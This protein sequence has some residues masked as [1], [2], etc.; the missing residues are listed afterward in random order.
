MKI[1]AITGN[2]SDYDLM[3]P[4][5]RY[6]HA[7]PD[8]N[9]QLLVSGA[10]L[11]SL[12]GYT[13]DAIR[14]DGFSILCQIETI[15]TA[16]DKKSRLN[17]AS[18]L[19]QHSIDP[20][21]QFNPDLILYV[22]DREEVIV[23]SLLSCYLEIPSMHF[24]S[25]DHASDGNTDN[26]IRHAAAKL[27]SLHMVSLPQHKDRLIAMGESADRIHYVGSMALDNFV[28]HQAHSKPDL[29]KMLSTEFDDFALV[30]YHPLPAER[31]TYF[32]SYANLLDALIE[33]NIYAFINAPN[34]DPGNHAGLKIIDHYKQYKNFVYTKNLPR[35]LFLSI[36]KNASFIIGNSSSGIVESASIPIPAINVGQR[37]RGRFA[38]ENVIFCGTSKA[39]ITTAVEKATTSEFLNSIKWIKNPYGDGHSA[40]RA[41]QFIKKLNFQ[42]YT[43]KN[44]DPLF[45]FN[46]FLHSNREKIF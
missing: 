40:V 41:Y 46:K 32:Q 28:Q 30:I 44:E 18:L 10:H 22:G 7:D 45:L 6:L 38:A 37:Q 4:L 43:Y 23:G 19:L 36:Y 29:R 9:L 34:T 12:Y 31:D 26:A 8:M 2:R 33:K 25:G 35:D 21:N 3:S 5:Y 20:V 27:A 42:K 1:L 17:S 14:K 24:W 16:D 15:T 39:D 13:I 11:S